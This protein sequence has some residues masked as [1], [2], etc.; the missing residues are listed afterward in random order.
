MQELRCIFCS[1]YLFSYEFRGEFNIIIK[2]E[3]C[4]KTNVFNF[5]RVVLTVTNFAIVNN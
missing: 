2:C 3:A 5:A 4:L 1:H